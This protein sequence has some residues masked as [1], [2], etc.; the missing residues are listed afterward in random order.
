MSVIGVAGI[1]KSRL[2]WEFEKYIDGLVDD[3]WWHRGRCLAYGE[4]VAFWALAEMVRSAPA[5]SR[6]S[7]PRRR[8]AK[9]AAG[10][11]ESGPDPEERAWIEPRL[12]TCSASTERTAPDQRGSLLGLAAVLRAPVRQGPAV[13]IFEDLHW[14]DAGLLDFVEYLL[15]W[16]R[17][18][19]ALRPHARAGR[20]CASAARPG[21]RQAGFHS[22]V[23]RAA[24]RRGER[25]AALGL[26]PGPPRRLRGCIRERAEG[27]PL[28]AVETVRMLL[29]RGALTREGD[30]YQVIGPIEALEVPETLHALIAA[31]LDGLDPWS[32]TCSGTPR[33]SERPSRSGA[34]GASPARRRRLWN[35]LLASLVRKE[36]LTI[37]A[38]PF[39]PE[40]GQYGFLHALVQKVAYETLSRRERKA[41]HLAVA[42]YLEAGWGQDEPEVVEVVAA[43]YLEAYRS[44]P[45][46]RTRVRSKPPPGRA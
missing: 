35:R 34:S 38:D 46:P 30:G 36:I 14:A 33:C 21:A 8:T 3:V 31:R 17:N 4:G 9:L 11:R 16:S 27:I 41:R 29:D 32:V 15:E 10:A 40:R 45:M 23:P 2:A 1:G 24:A 25:R 7:R 43:H 6:T 5:S 18:H 12:A 39:S 20:S 26:V 44:F 19:P 28:Y 37:Q 13:L 42:A 22:L